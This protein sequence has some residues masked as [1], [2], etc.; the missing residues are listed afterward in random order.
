MYVHRYLAAFSNSTVD[1]ACNRHKPIETKLIIPPPTRL[2]LKQ[3][4]SL[5]RRA[6]PLDRINISDATLAASCQ[7]CI[8]PN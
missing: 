1:T 4:D 6:K 3:H 8:L 5:R 7:Y 2:T